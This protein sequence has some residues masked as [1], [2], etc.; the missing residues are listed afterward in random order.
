MTG[1][2]NNM[3]GKDRSHSSRVIKLFWKN[4]FSSKIHICVTCHNQS[5]LYYGGSTTGQ[6]YT[7][8]DEPRT[9]RSHELEGQGQYWDILMEWDD[10]FIHLHTI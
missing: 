9:H 6:V 1:N 4:H 8:L 10:F 5:S 7:K 3:T 2:G